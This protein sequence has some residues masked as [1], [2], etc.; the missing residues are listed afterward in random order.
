MLARTAKTETD[1]FEPAEI[2]PATATVFAEIALF[3]VRGIRDAANSLIHCIVELLY[4]KE[5]LFL[6][7]TPI[8]RPINL[9]GIL[10][11]I[12]RRE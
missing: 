12:W 2:C 8:N 10:Q 5:K 7:G 3:L 11:L 9:V 6:T 4:A 1:T